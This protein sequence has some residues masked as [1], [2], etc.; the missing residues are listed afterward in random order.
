[1]L[2]YNDITT[3]KVIDYE[4]EPCKVVS[5]QVSRKQQNKPSNQTRLLSLKS[6]KTFD[7]TF[8]VSEKVQEA[9]LSKQPV[10][11]IYESKGELWF[12]EAGAPGK[13]FTL[14]HDLLGAKVKFLRSKDTYDALLFNEE[15]L[16]IDI[17][18]KMQLRVTEAAPAVKGNT[19]QGATK[20]VTV[21]TGATVNVPLFIN[22]GDIIDVNTETEEYSGRSEKS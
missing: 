18:I 8:H 2:A 14:P 3:G 6:N 1:M 21:E 5:H 9:D 15:I 4:G 22:E 16:G 7:V 13:R 19:A 12:H 11:Y 17:P 10:V 20:S